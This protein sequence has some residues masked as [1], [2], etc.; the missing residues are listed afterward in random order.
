M[1]F[2]QSASAVSLRSLT[3]PGRLLIGVLL[4]AA[5]PAVT[6]TDLL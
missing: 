3:S 4:L 6:L 2:L 1:S 5:A